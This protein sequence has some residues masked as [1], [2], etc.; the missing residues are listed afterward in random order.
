MLTARGAKRDLA[1]QFK[2]D[3]RLDLFDDGRLIG[4][5]ACD[6]GATQAALSVNDKPYTMAAAAAEQNEPLAELLQQAAAS[7]AKRDGAAL[8]L[9]DADGHTRALAQR[10]KSSFMVAHEGTVFTLRKSSFFSLPYHLYRT[11][12][13]Q[14]LGTVGQKSR[15]NRTLFMDLPADFD[16]AFQVFLL[17][18]SLHI[19]MQ[20][21]GSQ[22]TYDYT[23]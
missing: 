18:L 21:L 12:S 22:S 8:A 20:R 19:A 11:G 10:V 4:Q 2:L 5:L 16:T 13:E 17:L 3:R 6:V 1:S 14:S 15:F 23:G 9:K 7:H